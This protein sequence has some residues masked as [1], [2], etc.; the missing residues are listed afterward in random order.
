MTRMKSY[1]L[2]LQSLLNESPVTRSMVRSFH[3]C[4]GIDINCMSP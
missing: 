2:S 1:V 3:A 4:V